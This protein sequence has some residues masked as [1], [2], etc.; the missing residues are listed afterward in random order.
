[1]SI[2]CNLATQ[3]LRQYLPPRSLHNIRIERLWR[4]VRKDTLEFFRRI[5]MH[6]EAIDLLDMD[7]P[8]HRVCLFI[9]FRNR[10]QKSLDETLVSWNN[11]KVRTA[12]NKTPNAMYQL[13][14]EQAIN[15]GFWTGD[16]GDDL[17]E[18]SDD[19]GREFGDGIMPPAD[20]LADDP[21]APRSDYFPSAEAEHEAGIFVNN[22]DEIQGIK[23]ILGD[24][25]VSEE[26]DNN[27]INVY[28]EATL[29]VEAFLKKMDA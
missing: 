8:I 7:N 1:M 25:D 26:D 4:D 28:V 3:K 14:R 27:G 10:I 21:T 24:F 13:S 17:S 2:D 11:H 22:D 29:R 9:V 18:V 23:D 15:R 19:Y 20:K 5:F 16:P 6:L 12:G